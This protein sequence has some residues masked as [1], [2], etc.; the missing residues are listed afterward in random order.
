[1]PKFKIVTVADYKRPRG[2]FND[3]KKFGKPLEEIG[4]VPIDRQVDSFFRAGQNLVQS[5][6][7]DVDDPVYD[8]LLEVR[9]Y[10]LSEIGHAMVGLTDKLTASA[11][12][13]AE[14]LAKAEAGKQTIE[15]SAEVSEELGK[16]TSET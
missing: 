7:S 3:P 1:M 14:A 15:G 12:Q 8:P 16:D 10:D 11:R 9:D 13:Q 5:F 2:E 6:D 4:Y